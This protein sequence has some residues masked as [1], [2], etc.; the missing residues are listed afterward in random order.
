MPV[1]PIILGMGKND[2]FKA[3][4][5]P[6]PTQLAEL[7]IDVV[8]IAYA[9]A[10]DQHQIVLTEVIEPDTVTTAMWPNEGNAIV[11]AMVQLEL[12]DET[13]AAKLN[14]KE[15]VKACV[16]SLNNWDFPDET[17]AQAADKK[18]KKHKKAGKKKPGFTS[19]TT[20]TSTTTTTGAA[21]ARKLGACLP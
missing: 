18:G 13:E 4:H 10:T 15:A 14:I 20:T 16:E 1:L 19:G 9:Q 17:I 5:L 3:I 11:D 2:E 7:G 6:T 21:H 12:F 8:I